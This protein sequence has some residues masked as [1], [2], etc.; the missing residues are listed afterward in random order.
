MRVNSLT[1]LNSKNLSQAG[2]VNFSAKFRMPE[3]ADMEIFSKKV[4]N[5]PKNDMNKLLE[6]IENGI[7]AFE[8]NRKVINNLIKKMQ[9]AKRKNNDFSP[10]K[11]T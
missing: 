1:A 4:K 6:K 8:E 9:S 10:E 5:S 7:L 3:N 11:V 2:A